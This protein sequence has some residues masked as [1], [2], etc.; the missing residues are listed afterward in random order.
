MLFLRSFIITHQSYPYS[1]CHWKF[2]KF[3]KKMGQPGE[4]LGFCR[5]VGDYLFRYY[6]PLKP[7]RIILV[8]FGI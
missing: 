2:K 7:K 6:S 3:V 1:N 8:D 4:H 5:I